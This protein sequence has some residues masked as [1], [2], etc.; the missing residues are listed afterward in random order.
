MQAG[1]DVYVEKP[2][3]Y[4]VAEGRRVVET[5]RS[6]GRI[7]QVGLQSRS[8]LGMRRA[9]EFLHAGGIGPIRRVRGLCYKRRSPIGP[10]VAGSAPPNLNYQLWLGPAPEASVTRQRFHHDWHWQWAYGGGEL[11]NQG[12][13]QMDLAR[14]GLNVNEHAE[15]VFSF[16]GRFGP[17]DAAETADTQT[18]IHEIAN[19][20]IVFEVRG[21]KTKRV[22]GAKVGVIFEGETGFLVVASYAS[23]VAFDCKGNELKAFV[24]GGDH[25]ANFLSAVRSRRYSDLNAD[26]ETAHYSSSLGHTGNISYRLGDPLTVAE[27]EQTI[28]DSGYGEIAVDAVGRFVRHLRDNSIATSS[29]MILG[30][31]L[32]FDNTTEC[33]ADNA[34]ANSLLSREYREPYVC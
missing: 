4:C 29:P 17:A 28:G 16:G 12:V 2:G 15:T 30:P 25:F 32:A 9:M 31:K 18:V 22:R 26:I 5:A 20:Q 24:G 7:C 21:L 3:S 8:N 33:F 19:S 14:W 23:G 13:H 1:K 6:L 11:G 10:V 34:Q 27:V